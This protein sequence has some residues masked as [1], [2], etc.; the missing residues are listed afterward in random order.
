METGLYSL[1]DTLTQSQMLVADSSLPFLFLMKI[2][3]KMVRTE[4]ECPAER[5]EK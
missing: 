5:A 3:V 1:Q 2:D 4:M